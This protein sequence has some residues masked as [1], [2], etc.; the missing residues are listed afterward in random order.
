M[1]GILREEPN[2][3]GQ[4]QVFS[5]AGLAVNTWRY[6]ELHYGERIELVGVVKEGNKIEEVKDV[7]ILGRGENWRSG[8]IRLRRRIE[9]LYRQFLPEPQASLLAGIVLGSKD[10]PA[11]FSRFLQKT[12]T[13]HIV[14][15]SGMNVTLVASTLLSFLLLFLSRRWALI[16]AF[17]GIWFYVFLAGVEIPVIRAGIMGSLAFLAQGLGREED[18]WRGLGLAAFFFLFLDPLTIFDLGFQLSFCATAGILFFSSGISNLLKGLPVQ[19]RNDFAQTLSAQLAV[20]PLILLTFGRYSLFSLPA[21][22]LIVTILP[23]MMKLGAI[24]AIGGLVFAPLGQLLS[25]FLWPILTYVV[26]VVEL[27]G[28]LP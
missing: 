22:F 12:G 15:A 18:A 23:L 24:V 3:F 19:L 6:P 4:R 10:L 11:D 21:N 5:L 17:G 26:K 7:R 2:V 8:I 1:T 28:S 14:V 9:E 20:L 25:F 13:I 16:L 27:F